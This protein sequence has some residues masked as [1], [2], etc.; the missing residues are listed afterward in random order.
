MP[1]SKEQKN[2][3]SRNNLHFPG[4]GPQDSLQYPLKIVALEM[5]LLKST[6]RAL[7]SNPGIAGNKKD[8]TVIKSFRF[9]SVAA[10]LAGGLLATATSAYADTVFSVQY[11]AAPTGSGDFHNGGVPT[12]GVTGSNYVTGTL[13]PNGLP[14]FVGSGF[15]NDGGQTLGVGSSYLD[16]SSQILYWTPGKNGIVSAGTGTIDFTTTPTV[17]MFVAAPLNPDPGTNSAYEETA[18]LTGTFVT[19]GAS[20]P[21]QF[22]VGA[23]DEAFVYLDGTLIETLAG[24]HGL[25]PGPSA[26]EDVAAG[27]HTVQI[28][29]AD[30]DV[31]N[32]QLSFSETVGDVT[33]TPSVPEPS[34]F[35]LLGTG[36]LGAAGALRRRFVS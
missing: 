11:F 1:T 19:T 27:T 5:L 33:I 34:T 35:M 2:T 32:A 10:I 9:A 28:F 7:H 20:T 12:D 24:I 23:D 26:L 30:Q 17:S 22:T 15:N 4:A 36:L 3:Q 14:V 25:N 6:P 18:I 21:V 29:Y 31:T 8:N 16:S 13:G